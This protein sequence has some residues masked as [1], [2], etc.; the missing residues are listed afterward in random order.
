[1]A[2]WQGS[3]SI[4]VPETASGRGRSC[5]EK[6]YP[7]SFA[8][9]PFDFILLCN[10]YAMLL[11]IL[12]LNSQ[13]LACLDAHLD[14]GAGANI[15]EGGGGSGM[16]CLPLIFPSFFFKKNWRTVLGLNLAIWTIQFVVHS[17]TFFPFKAWCLAYECLILLPSLRWIITLIEWNI[18]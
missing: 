3:W 12:F 15:W 7:I 2:F 16:Q 9:F 14:L 17:Y 4:E 8:S 6:V 5:S 13:C 18:G 10:I 11:L 1:M